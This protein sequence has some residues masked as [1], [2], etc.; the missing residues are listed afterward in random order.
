MKEYL[1]FNVKTSAVSLIIETNLGLCFWEIQNNVTACNL[2]LNSK[3]RFKTCR[4][5][6]INILQYS[7]FGEKTLNSFGYVKVHEVSL[8]KHWI[9][10]WGLSNWCAT[11]LFQSKKAEIKNLQFFICNG[12]EKLRSLKKVNYFNIFN[13]FKEIFPRVTAKFE[14]LN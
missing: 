3:Q 11:W 8:S 2:I 12:I 9:T 10:Q 1:L 13:I 6:I 4:I 7:F 5:K 14:Y